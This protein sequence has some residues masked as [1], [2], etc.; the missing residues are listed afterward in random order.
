MSDY[1]DVMAI[2]IGSRFV[3]SKHLGLGDIR[4]TPDEQ[5]SIVDYVQRLERSC[6]EW[7]E[8]NHRLQARIDMFK[9]HFEERGD[10]E[11]KPINQIKAEG[12]RE[13]GLPKIDDDMWEMFSDTSLMTWDRESNKPHWTQDAVDFVCYVRNWNAD[14][15]EK[16]D[17]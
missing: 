10:R 7:N 11:I 1:V 4:L 16:G 3:E 17:D 6:H 2:L 13:I 8:V 9:E 15:L 14:E 5:D 12:I